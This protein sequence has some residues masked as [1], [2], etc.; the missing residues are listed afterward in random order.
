MNKIKNKCFTL[1]LKRSIQK[2]WPNV[3]N[4]FI[5]IHQKYLKTTNFAFFILQKINYLKYLIEVY[6]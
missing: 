1:V 3:L 6:T 4:A 5:D 2:R